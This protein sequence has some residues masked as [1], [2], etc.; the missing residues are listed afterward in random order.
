[1]IY[2][3]IWLLTFSCVVFVP[4][5]Y[6]RNY[7]IA[8][9]T[10]ILWFLAAFR[11]SNID[12][13]YQNYLTYM[14]DVLRYGNSSPGGIFFDSIVYGLNCV[15][16]P[17]TM[18]FAFY[19]ISIPLK[20]KL[21][22]KFENYSAA[23]FL[24]YIGFFI[25]LHDFT[26]VRAGLAI[27]IGYWSVYIKY[28]SHGKKWFPLMLLGCLIHPSIIFLLIFI[29]ID[30]YLPLKAMLMVLLLSIAFSFFDIIAPVANKIVAIVNNP[31]I[32]L[33]YHLA[34]DGQSIKPFGVFPLFN[35]VVTF[36]SFYLVPRV[37]DEKI[38]T[39]FIKF[40]LMSQICWFLLY[41]IP[42]MAGRLN[43]IFLFSIIFLT[44]LLSKYLF[45]NYF[46]V[47]VLYSLVGFAA[48][49][50]VGNLMN[51]YSINLW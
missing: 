9:I 25:Y 36:C 43:Q 51:E 29:L 3:S 6:I 22:L 31:T 39:V 32:T 2:N 5:R 50:W 20:Y 7:L 1:M 49:I 45:R 42:V 19:A 38:N 21:F 23:I 8:G 41:P 30:K 37:S 33:Y 40:L 12:A 35:L 11:S 48:F 14:Q 18:I 10:F 26:Q 46:V 47:P 27:A 13:D 16:L 15:G 34:I 4:N 17:I 44:P 28:T 24:G